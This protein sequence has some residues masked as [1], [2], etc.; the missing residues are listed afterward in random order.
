M[1]NFFRP[2]LRGAEAAVSDRNPYFTGFAEGAFDILLALSCGLVAGCIFSLDALDRET[3]GKPKAYPEEKTRRQKQN[4]ENQGSSKAYPK[5]NK[6][7]NE[8][9]GRPK[10]YPAKTPRQIG[11]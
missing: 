10:A 8:N 2:K 7:K 5:N 11:R 6:R 4:N 1:Q 9:R 3:R